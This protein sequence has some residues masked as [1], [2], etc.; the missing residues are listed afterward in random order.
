M[1]PIPFSSRHLSSII[2]NFYNGSK[3]SRGITGKHLLLKMFPIA[4]CCVGPLPPLSHN[5]ISIFKHRR[6][7]TTKKIETNF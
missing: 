3:N 2:I 5:S 1:G 6:F 4:G 7:N